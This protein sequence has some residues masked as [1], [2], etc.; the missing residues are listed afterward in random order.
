MC[1]RRRL[2]EDD[3]LAVL[4]GSGFTA[5]HC[6]EV[7]FAEVSDA[8]RRGR[9][10]ERVLNLRGNVDASGMAHRAPATRSPDVPFDLDRGQ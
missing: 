7:A 2:D 3:L 8:R 5:D 10:G 4:F 6:E 9:G 1:R